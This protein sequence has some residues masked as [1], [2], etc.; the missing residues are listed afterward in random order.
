MLAF[1]EFRGYFSQS[2]R[3]LQQARQS[4]RRVSLRENGFSQENYFIHCSS[5][6]SVARFVKLNLVLC[7]TVVFGNESRVLVI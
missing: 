5:E 7:H 2:G 1:P 4:R 6:C 3:D